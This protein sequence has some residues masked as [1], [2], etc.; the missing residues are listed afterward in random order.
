[1]QSEQQL[2]EPIRGQE[3]NSWARTTIVERLPDILSRTVVENDFPPPVKAELEALHAEIPGARI[4]PIRD[5]QA[6]DYADWKTFTAPYLDDDWLEV[7]WFFAEHYFYRRIMD[8]VS[9]FQHRKDPFLSQK[10]KGYRNNRDRIRKY[11]EGLGERLDDGGLD[12]GDVRDV[13]HLSLWGN[14][15]DLSLW[16]AD[17][18]SAPDH[19]DADSAQEH[20]LADQSPAITGL[21]FGRGRV[22]R[23]DVLLDNAGFEFV[24]DLGLV[25][26]FLTSGLVHQ[27]VLWAKVHP[28][29]VSDLTS[30]DIGDGIVHLLQ[31][32][33]AAVKDLGQRLADHLES[34]RLRIKEDFY[35]NS[36]LPLRDLPLPLR[37]EFSESSLVISKGDANYRRL[38]GDRHWDFTTPF[39]AVV[40]FFPA[41]LAALRALKA[42]L[43]V[44]L[45]RSAIQRAEKGDS[46]WMINGRWGVIQWAPG[47][48]EKD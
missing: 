38:V 9:Y 11:A 2:P 3:D 37:K 23:V 27:V 43:A 31:D 36:P 39:A 21:L 26:L 6:P 35:W 8:A 1:M 42:E 10:R 4:R 25:D 17:G 5:V 33:N 47:P 32:D 24:T 7:P 22:P 15:G 16:P 12:Q 46:E 48:D 29:F 18:G 34:G 19:E 44:G 20:L 45:D 40:D 30:W 41:P 14:Q 28:T 13:L